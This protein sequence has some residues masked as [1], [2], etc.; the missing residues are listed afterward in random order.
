MTDKETDLFFSSL[1]LSVRDPDKPIISIKLPKARTFG[2]KVH[3][4]LSFLYIVIRQKNG[5]S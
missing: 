1:F 4:T 3:L 5:K 2:K